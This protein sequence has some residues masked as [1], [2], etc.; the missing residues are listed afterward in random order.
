MTDQGPIREAAVM[1]PPPGIDVRMGNVVTRL[2]D[3]RIRLWI[4]VSLVSSGCSAW[5]NLRLARFFTRRSRRDRA[6]T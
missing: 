3:S 1:R 6:R 4:A 2:W 5:V